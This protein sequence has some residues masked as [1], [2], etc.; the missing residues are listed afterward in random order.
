VR[1]EAPE[2]VVART[3]D[4]MRAMAIAGE[5][6]LEDSRQVKV[7]VSGQAVESVSERRDLGLGI[8]VFD[9]DGAGFAFT[10]DFDDDA[11]GA[12]VTAAREIARH[13]GPDD[14]WRLPEPVPVDPLPFPNVDPAAASVTEADRIEIAMTIESAA[15]ATD[16][17]IR[18]TREAALEDYSGRTWV[19]STAGV[20]T[21]YEYSRAVGRLEVTA[22]EGGASQVGFHVEFALGAGS[23]DPAEIGRQGAAKA[24]AKLGGE[25]A[26]TGRM[27]VVLDREVVAGLMDALSPAF[28]ARRVLKGTSVLAGRLGEPVAAAGVR[29]VDDPRLP[30]GFG[31]APADGEG[32]ATRPVSLIEDGRLRGYLHDTFSHHKLARTEMSAG[33]PG[34]SI[35]HSY[36]SPPQVGT[37]NLVLLPGT[38]PPE[39]LVDRARGGVWVKEVM[40]L[41]TVDPIT[42]DFS[43][44]G[45][46]LRIENGRP[47]RPVDRMALSGNLLELLRG[48]EAVGSDLKLFT[49]GGG[50]PSVLLGDVSVAG[51]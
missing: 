50:A 25:P 32:L 28:S 11:V 41:H 47:G 16:P 36:D 5:V 31:S 39:V 42:G 40:G 23:L 49:G 27:P 30:G 37:M 29:V 33:R 45:S 6:Y 43:L 51:S 46:G 24:L 3:V 15:R 14:A 48:I 22:S 20:A 18:K 9:A 12:T 2:T 8:R 17:R 1:D 34:N 4:A 21:S 13:T 35:R 44:G 26:R 38:E 10:T 19:A 7:A